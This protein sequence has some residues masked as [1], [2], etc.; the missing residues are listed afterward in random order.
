MTETAWAIVLILAGGICELTAAIIAGVELHA[1][2]RLAAPLRHGPYMGTENEWV[3]RLA[4]HN[5]TGTNLLLVQ[6]VVEAFL[7]QLESTRRSRAAVI[8][9]VPAG[10][11]LAM[12]GDLV[13]ALK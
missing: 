9:L 8:A 7:K 3:E 13:A 4:V 5:E 11:L 12:A 10:I 2:V 6:R 1:A